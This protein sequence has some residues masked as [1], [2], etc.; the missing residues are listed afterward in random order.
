[1]PTRDSLIFI[2]FLILITLS[3]YY[4]SFSN[5]F[6]YD[7]YARIVDNA[8]IRQL[9]AKSFISYFMDRNTTAPD[10]D[11]SQYCWRPIATASFALDYELWKLNARFY[12][13]ENAVLHIINVIL[14]YIIILLILGSGFTAFL[15]ALVF[16]IHPVQTEVV[17]WIACR[18]SIL[19]VLFSLLAFLFHVKNK[20][21]GYNVYYCLSLIFFTLGLLSKEMAIV[22]PGILI[23]YDLH[24]DNHRKV[25]F[26]LSYYLPFFLIAISYLV[27]R[28][29][30]LGGIVRPPEWWG[31]S[32]FYNILTVVKSVV[33]YIRLLILP[34]NLGVE[35]PVIIS[36][37]IVEKEVLG[38][39][40]ILLAIIVFWIKAR[41]KKEIS[42][43]LA[44]FF[45]ALAPA[46]NI[47][48]FRAILAERFLYLPAIA[49]A[50]LFGIFFA[51]LVRSKRPVVKNAAAFALI[52]IF[53]LYAFFAMSRSLQWKN[54]ITLYSREVA[55]LPLNSGAHYNLGFAY[56]KY[57]QCAGSADTA[58]R[59]Y[60]LAIKEFEK[61][62]RL[63]P[64]YYLLYFSY[65][66]LAE[67]YNAL[68]QYNLAVK[69]FKKARRIR[70]DRNDYDN[71]TAASFRKGNFDEAL[72][73]C[74]QAIFANP[75]NANSYLNLG[76]IYFIK[77]ERAR[78][79]KAWL[80]AASLTG[81]DPKLI[82]YI[83]DL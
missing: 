29:F 47:V 63:R 30:V 34:A 1:M 23:A 4:N 6:A 49:F 14:V 27:A 10:E 61:T 5:S 62:I 83:N 57:A 82:R 7:D 19:F 31:G 74:K 11:L 73:F 58:G 81:N 78:A 21:S 22:L 17:A 69:N 16:A 60:A 35:Y 66:N 67:I 68:G 36:R 28:F 72:G 42:F 24:F 50:S 39:I 45:I 33:E 40:A 48:P 32:I 9:N 79:K 37:S 15:A 18:S 8:A 38:A 46:Y 2:A 59:Y 65:S 41:P 51:K 75:D 13:I 26:Y 3:V 25:R 52:L 12:H 76:N 77:N 54:E 55:R 70:E 56:T 20:K 80:K 53:I 64:E 44:W 71:L 43:F